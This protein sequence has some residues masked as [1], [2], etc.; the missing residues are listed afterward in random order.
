[1]GHYAGEV[2]SAWLGVNVGGGRGKCSVLLVLKQFALGKLSTGKTHRL[3]GLSLQSHYI[4]Y[5]S[6]K[7]LLPIQLQKEEDIIQH[8]VLNEYIQQLN[9][10]HNTPFCQKIVPSQMQLQI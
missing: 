3:I 8:I 4:Y 9:I 7:L 1:M 10:S 6:L 2:V 5:V